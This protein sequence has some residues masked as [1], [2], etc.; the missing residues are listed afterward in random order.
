MVIRSVVTILLL[1]NQK[2]YCIIDLN[3]I[4]FGVKTT[5]TDN[6]KFKKSTIIKTSSDRP[7]ADE[8]RHYVSKEDFYQAL[9]IRNKLVKEAEDADEP[10]PQANDFIGTCVIDIC[11]NLAKKHQFSGYHFKD[12]MI[13]DAIY[14][15]IRYI[16]SFDVEKS[17]NPFSYFTQAA[18]YQFIKRIQ[19]EKEQLYIRCKAT[20]SSA[21][22]NETSESD[23]AGNDMPTN[24]LGDMDTDFMDAYILEYEAK[25]V[26]KKLKAKTIKREKDALKRKESNT[27]YGLD[28]LIEE[29]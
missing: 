14:H 12:E 5:M 9:I 3:N 26:A 7:D 19:Q 13:A 16:D 6:Y 11:T 20:Q 25:D 18:Y 29:E 21:M 8:S 28:L 10:K 2:K 22:L 1:T 17:D 24:I 15:C 23:S 4:T 27:L